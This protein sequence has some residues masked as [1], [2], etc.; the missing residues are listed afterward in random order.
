MFGGGRPEEEMRSAQAGDVRIASAEAAPVQGRSE[1]N[2]D[3]APIAAA[4]E[5]VDL[6]VWELR[7]HLKEEPTG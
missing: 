7:R 1:E 5:A 3:E 2:A 6:M 4:E